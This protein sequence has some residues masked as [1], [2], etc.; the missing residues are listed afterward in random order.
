MGD[1]SLSSMHKST[2]LYGGECSFVVAYCVPFKNIY[3]FWYL[4]SLNIY[5]MTDLRQPVP[6]CYP[7][8]A[9]LLKYLS[10]LFFQAQRFMRADASRALIAM[11]IPQLYV[12]PLMMQPN[13]QNTGRKGRFILDFCTSVCVIMHMYLR[14]YLQHHFIY[15]NSLEGIRGRITYWA[16][17]QISCLDECISIHY[18][19]TM[20]HSC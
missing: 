20:K 16:F 15:P 18:N 13:L 6:A 8:L 1:F 14:R 11:E 7:C 4:L 17:C 5:F 3:F 2:C 10:F 19:Y 9:F 12:I